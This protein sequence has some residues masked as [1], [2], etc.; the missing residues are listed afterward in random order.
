M[1]GDEEQAPE[2]HE[3]S[4]MGHMD[5]SCMQ[6]DSST[7]PS[8]KPLRERENWKALEETPLPTDTLK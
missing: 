2:A 1:Q 8:G 7:N 5:S 3:A 6:P 4:S